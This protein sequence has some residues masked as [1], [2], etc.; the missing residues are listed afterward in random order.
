ME[1]RIVALGHG[2]LFGA[3]YFEKEHNVVDPVTGI[4]DFNEFNVYL[5]LVCLSWKWA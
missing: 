1:F 3:Q 5:F 4:E 2:V